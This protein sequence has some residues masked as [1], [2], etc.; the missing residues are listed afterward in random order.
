MLCAKE[1]SQ[2]VAHLISVRNCQS[3]MH[4]SPFVLWSYSFNEKWLVERILFRNN[5]N[6]SCL[7]EIF[8]DFAIRNQTLSSILFSHK[9]SLCETFR[10]SFV[11]I[12]HQSALKKHYSLFCKKNLPSSFTFQISWL[13]MDILPGS[14]K[15]VYKSA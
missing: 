15:N 11:I 7:C 5:K 14:V 13:G 2:H 10:R 12:L 1:E 3:C 6:V 9:T 4:A 8:F